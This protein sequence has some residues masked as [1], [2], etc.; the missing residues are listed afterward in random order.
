[1]MKQN[2]KHCYK[3][4]FYIAYNKGTTTFERLTAFIDHFF[5]FSCFLIYYATYSQY[6]CNYIGL[7]INTPCRHSINRIYPGGKLSIQK[8]CLISLVS[9]T[10]VS[11]PYCP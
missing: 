2:G 10:L 6:L 9:L 8:M 1:M 5:G 4:I 3:Y 7:K 11:T